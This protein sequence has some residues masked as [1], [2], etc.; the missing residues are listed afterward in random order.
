MFFSK[1]PEWYEEPLAQLK[2]L[3]NRVIY[4]KVTSGPWWWQSTHEVVRWEE[5][6]IAVIIFITLMFMRSVKR[7]FQRW[8]AKRRI[9]KS[10]GAYSPEGLLPGSVIMPGKESGLPK[11]QARIALKRGDSYVV[12]GGGIRIRDSLMLPTHVLYAGDPLYII[13]PKGEWQIPTDKADSISAD[14]SAVTMYKWSEIGIACAK[15][16]PLMNKTTI[17]VMSSCDFSFSVGVLDRGAT[18]GRTAYAASTQP[19]FSGAA[20]MNGNVCVGMHCNGGAVAG[21]G[22]ESLYMYVR[23]NIS[24]KIADEYDMDSAYTPDPGTRFEYEELDSITINGKADRIAVV[25]DSAGRYHQTK[26]ELLEKIERM[27]DSRDWADQ[28][29]ACDAEDDLRA[30]RYAPESRRPPRGGPTYQ[31]EVLVGPQ[32]AHFSGEGRPP[33]GRAPSGARPSQPLP[34]SKSLTKDQQRPPTERD[35]LM[36]ALNSVSSREL[37]TFLGSRSMP[38]TSIRTSQPTLPLQQNGNPFIPNSRESRHSAPPQ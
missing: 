7:S 16:G 24:L 26:A 34:A 29:D 25:R 12:I 30:G 35:Q 19:G 31:P 32:G 8:L 15:L 37:K 18:F 1:Q 28:M 9:V 17:S 13:T 36:K 33:A 10:E 4:K 11:C 3:A 38:S 22:Y 23:L 27:K 21:G 2:V 20:Y 14:L 5:F 6:G